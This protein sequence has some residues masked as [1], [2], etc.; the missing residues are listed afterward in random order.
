MPTRQIRYKTAVEVLLE[1][2]G[3]RNAY[4]EAAAAPDARYRVLAHIQ[5]IGAVP[6]TRAGVPLENSEWAVFLLSLIHI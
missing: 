3:G 1:R 2:A 6:K 4:G 5:P